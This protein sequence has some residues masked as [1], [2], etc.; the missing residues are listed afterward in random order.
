MKRTRNCCREM[1]PPPPPQRQM[2]LR[3]SKKAMRS[4]LPQTNPGPRIYWQKFLR[5]KCPVTL[6][7]RIAR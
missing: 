6:S 5:S 7:E 2:R 4:H 1:M 3:S